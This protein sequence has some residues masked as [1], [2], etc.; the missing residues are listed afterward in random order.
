MLRQSNMPNEN[1]AIRAPRQKPG[2]SALPARK[3]RGTGKKQGKLF[4][5]ALGWHGPCDDHGTIA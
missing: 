2:E 1:N 3:Q 4:P 5:A